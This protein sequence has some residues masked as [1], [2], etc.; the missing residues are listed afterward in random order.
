MPFNVFNNGNQTA[1]LRLNPKAVLTIACTTLLCTTMLMGCNRSE[2]EH[3]AVD[4]RA[5]LASIDATASAPSLSRLDAPQGLTQLEDAAQTTTATKNPSASSTK[6]QV[7]VLSQ[8]KTEPVRQFAPTQHDAK[9]LAQLQQFEDDFSQRSD[10]MEVMLQQQLTK[11]SASEYEA[12][13]QQEKNKNLQQALQQLNA[14][15]LKSSQ[16][17]YIQQLL[18]Q[19]WQNQLKNLN[20]Q[21]R[22][23]TSNAQQLGNSAGLNTYLQAQQQLNAWRDKQK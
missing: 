5:E 18:V 7:D 23:T 13:Q 22:A 9:D 8:L 17:Q 15:Q 4:V 14:M 6:G 1:A 10:N 20:Q 3:D 2:P 21:Q 12:L 16:G 19:F 11:L